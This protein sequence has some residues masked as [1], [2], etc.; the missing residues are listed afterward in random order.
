LADSFEADLAF[1]LIDET[2]LTVAPGL[3][4]L[5]VEQSRLIGD[6]LVSLLFGRAQDIIAKIADVAS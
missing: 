4:P 3:K 2:T 1:A 5:S 6:A